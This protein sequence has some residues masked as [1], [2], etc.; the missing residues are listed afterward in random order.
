[1]S[2]VVAHL[3]VYSHMCVSRAN[4]VDHYAVL[5]VAQTAAQPEIKKA[6]RKLALKYHPD[7]L[8]GDAAKKEGNAKFQEVSESFAV[9]SD[10][11]KRMVR[12]RWAI[13]SWGFLS[14]SLLI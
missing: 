3:T 2:S 1:M 14:H 11:S 7:R 13:L 8:K 4:R 12:H 10:E 9:L 5:G 6:Y